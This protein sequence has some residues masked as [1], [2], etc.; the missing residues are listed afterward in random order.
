MAQAKC[1]V[2]YEGDSCWVVCDAMDFV[3]RT[4]KYILWQDGTP[5]GLLKAYRKHKDQ[6][7]KGH[8]VYFMLKSASILKNHA[9]LVEG[10]P[11]L[12]RYKRKD[13]S[14]LQS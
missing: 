12:Y 14:C 2:F 7:S 4:G 11:D 3:G 6:I 9:E 1:D 5:Y 13:K 8:D 10:T